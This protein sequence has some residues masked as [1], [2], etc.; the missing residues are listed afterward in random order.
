MSGRDAT[1][2]SMPRKRATG[3]G[4]VQL[5]AYS[6]MAGAACLSGLPTPTARRCPR[7]SHSSDVTPATYVPNT[8]EV[9]VFRG[10]LAVSTKLLQQ[11]LQQSSAAIY[12]LR[13]DKQA[14]PMTIASAISTS[15]KIHGASTWLLSDSHEE[16]QRVFGH[17]MVYAYPLTVEMGMD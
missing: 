4:E 2:L 15:I 8:A 11:L 14:C 1:P 10:N 3:T 5:V 17:G 13:E 12:H 7:A 16:A 9:A 6:A